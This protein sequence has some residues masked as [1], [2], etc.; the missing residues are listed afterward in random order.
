MFTKTIWH[1]KFEFPNPEHEKP[2]SL[3]AIFLTIKQHHIMSI[4]IRELN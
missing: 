4:G 1:R 3:L 2:I